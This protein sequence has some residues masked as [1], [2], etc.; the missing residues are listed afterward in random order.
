MFDVVAKAFRVD[1]YPAFP[2]KFFRGLNINIPNWL[3]CHINKIQDL[4]IFEE[5]SKPNHV[6]INEYLPGQGISPHLD[7]NLFYP[8]IATISLGSH[9]VLNFYEESTHK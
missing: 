5:H 7:G 2:L 8:T 3:Q 9:T 1:C 6:L 4:S